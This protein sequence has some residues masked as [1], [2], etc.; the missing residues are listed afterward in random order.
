MGI[1]YDLPFMF[2]EENLTR[3]QHVLS[4]VLPKY[5]REGSCY[6]FMKI[7]QMMEYTHAVFNGLENSRKSEKN[8]AKR[9]FKMIQAQ[10]NKFKSNR[11]RYNSKLRKNEIRITWVAMYIIVYI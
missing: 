5:I 6:K 2:P 4:F 8:R 10:E 9:F 7:E 11:E 3:K 1:G